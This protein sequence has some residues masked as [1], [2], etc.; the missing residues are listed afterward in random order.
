MGILV[1]IGAGATAAVVIFVLTVFVFGMKKTKENNT[2]EIHFGMAVSQL[3]AMTLCCGYLLYSATEI[4]LG[5]AMIRGAFIS[6]GAAVAEVLITAVITVLADR[7]YRSDDLNAHTMTVA[8]MVSLALNSI[9]AAVMLVVS[10]SINE[11]I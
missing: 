7:R 9:A 8:L 11:I 2:R 3:A 6:A 1:K 5:T 4:T 10:L